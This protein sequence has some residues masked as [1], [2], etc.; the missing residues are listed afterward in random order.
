MVEIKPKTRIQWIDIARGLAIIMVIIGHSQMN[1]YGDYWTR[2]LFSVHL[3]I[4]FVLSGY[5]YRPKNYQKEL[6]GG[7]FNLILP[8][9]ATVVIGGILILIA[10]LVPNAYI[11]PYRIFLI[12]DLILSGLYG[13]NETVTLF[14][15]SIIGIGAIWFLLAFFFG[16]QI[17]NLIMRLQVSDSVKAVIVLICTIAGVT[18]AQWF[19]LP[20]SIDSALFAQIFFFSG[21]LIKKYDLMTRLSW[22]IVII[23]AV[24]YVYSGTQGTL[25]VANVRDDTMVIGV[26]AGITNSLFLM[27]VSQKIEAVGKRF[28]FNWLITGLAFM[29]AESL[30]ILC[31]HLIDLDYLHV[32]VHVYGFVYS[33]AGQLMATYA[34]IFYRTIFTI[35][36]VLIVRQIPIIRSFYM[37]RK[38]P[39]KSK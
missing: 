18:I 26:I 10:R 32:W 38:Y 12:K 25:S 39:F 2:L 7:W 17:F 27:W 33:H 1:Y 13:V 3:P 6:K 21:Y 9:F 4:F 35:L 24:I 36:M 20:W 23:L 14:H 31:F 15:R 28:K 22:W 30:T 16:I 11:L 8:Y 37:H 29:G 34:G 19:Y 5:L